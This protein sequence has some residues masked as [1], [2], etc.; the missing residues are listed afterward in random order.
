MSVP[1]ITGLNL[2]P[3]TPFTCRKG[4]NLAK[5]RKVRGRNEKITVLECQFT[6]RTENEEGKFTFQDP[7][8][9]RLSDGTRSTVGWNGFIYFPPIES[10]TLSG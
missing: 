1:K 8:S 3:V 6:E 10:H 2:C 4:R 7:N 5:K 9:I